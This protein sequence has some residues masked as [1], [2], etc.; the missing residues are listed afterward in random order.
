MNKITAKILV[1]HAVVALLAWQMWATGQKAEFNQV[2]GIDFQLPSLG[3]FILLIAVLVLGYVL[4]QK[5]RW[6]LSTAGIIGALF[7]VFFGWHWLNLV[8]VGIFSLF[9]LWSANRVRREIVERK[10]LNISD[11]FYHGLTP[12]VLGLFVMISFAAYQSPLLSDIKKSNKLPGQSQVF[13]QQIVDKTV[14]QKIP[15]S[16]S[17]AQR[18]K[19]INEVVT[20]TIQEFNRILKPYFQYAPPLLAFGLFLIL[21]GLSFIFVWL[22]IV[23]G[24]V[25]FWILRKTHVV[26]VEERDVK[27]E[28]LV[29]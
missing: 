10:V 9:N 2:T 1:W 18:Q 8:A 24:M 15:D 23:V 13:I 11:A 25:L 26:N 4:F 21:S 19:L 29:V 5:R 28:V 6:S 3:T 17:P 27:A 20:Q 22:G 14:G 7:L 16:A 12:V